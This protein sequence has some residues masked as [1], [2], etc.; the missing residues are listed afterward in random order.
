MAD[1]P[2]TKA[3]DVGLPNLTARD[4]A[5][6]AASANRILIE[7]LIKVGVD[8][9]EIE[10]VFRAKAQELI[11]EQYEDNAANLLRVMAGVS[12][13]RQSDE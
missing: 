13:P 11:V 10:G 7:F 8:R 6:A 1:T 9:D 5:L 12:R 2:E 3:F 4:V